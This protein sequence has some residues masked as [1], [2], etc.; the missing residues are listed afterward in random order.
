MRVERNEG[1]LLSAWITR[2][3]HPSTHPPTHPSISLFISV[4]M[5][6]IVP[7]RVF[8]KSSFSCKE[9]EAHTA[10]NPKP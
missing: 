8:L 5:P 3:I 1:L 6:A 2:S 9:E 7:V 10:S 4:C